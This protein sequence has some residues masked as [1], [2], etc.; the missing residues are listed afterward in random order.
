MWFLGTSFW[1]LNNDPNNIAM[2]MPKEGS[3]EEPYNIKIGSLL[4]KNNAVDMLLKKYFSIYTPMPAVALCLWIALFMILLAA[5]KGKMKYV[6]IF[7]PCIGNILTLLI[8]TPITYWPRYG[9]SFICLLPV[10]L[11]FPYLILDN[12]SRKID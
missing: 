12:N 11:V 6:L 5:V 7:V 9:L 4:G 10:C 2:G 8:A 3:L 1:E